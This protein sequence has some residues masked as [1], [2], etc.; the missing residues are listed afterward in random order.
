MGVPEHGNLGDSAIVIA[1]RAFF[2]NLGVPDNGIVEHLPGNF[3]TISPLLRFSIRRQCILCSPGGG[4]MGD[5]YDWEECYRHAFVNAFPNNPIIIFP[6]TL[7]YTNSEKGT[8]LKNRSIE[9]YNDHLRLCICARERP[10]FEQMQNLYR[11]STIVL[12]PDIV[13]AATRE[14]FGVSDQLRQGALLCMRSD[15]EKSVPHEVISA[16]E[17]WLDSKGF[18]YQYVDTVINEHITPSNRFQYV[19]QKLNEF[20]A[21]K[22]II[23]DRLHG[24]IFSALTET[25][26]IVFKNY[27]HKVFETYKWLKGCPY[28]KFVEDEQKIESYLEDIF[29]IEECHFPP[30]LL[31]KDF[32]PLKQYIRSLKI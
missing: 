11:N 29:K 17:N 6:Q 28:I 4:N 9:V 12:T 27:N 7:Y 26:C 3:H 23:T 24:M 2:R 31:S 20:A 16:M 8:F 30:D 13:L 18:Q 5:E 14:T 32:E 21:A 15:R 19:S 22:L 25:P 10:S 1:M